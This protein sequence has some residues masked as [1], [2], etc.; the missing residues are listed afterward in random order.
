MSS[1][2]IIGGSQYR[3]PV[4]VAP[5]L[6]SKGLCIELHRPFCVLPPSADQAERTNYEN[7]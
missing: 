7:Q 6:G 4:L 5:I 2:C 3:Y 1:H